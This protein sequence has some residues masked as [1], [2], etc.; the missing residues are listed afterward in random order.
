[1]KQVIIYNE[2]D[3]EAWYKNA[4]ELL[5]KSK[6]GI[7]II[8]KKANRTAKQNSAFH[9]TLSEYSAKLNEAGYDFTD[10]INNTKSGYKVSWTPENLKQIF[11]KTTMAMY[12]KSSTTQLTTSEIQEA[13]QVFSH[14]LSEM[15]GVFV[16]WHSEEPPIY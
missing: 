16:E 4:Q 3:L 9:S 10:F 1:M 6:A 13:Y 12:N 2:I 11:K 8:T 15:S 7:T 14:R 5:G